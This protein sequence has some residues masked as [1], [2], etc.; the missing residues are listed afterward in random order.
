MIYQQEM[1]IRF[2]CPFN[3]KTDSPSHKRTDVGNWHAD[4]ENGSASKCR[5]KALS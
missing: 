5:N 1:N 4:P 3:V 2:V